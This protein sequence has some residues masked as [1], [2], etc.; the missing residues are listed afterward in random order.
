MKNKIAYCLIFLFVIC[1]LTLFFRSKIFHNTT[2]TVDN[3]NVNIENS[4][5]Y[6]KY[7]NTSGVTVV[8]IWAT[9]CKP[10]MEE[11]PALNKLK[12]QY[13]D[14]GVNFIS[15]SIDNIN[16][17]EKLKKFNATKKFEWDDITLENLE[18]LKLLQNLFYNTTEGS[19]F[20]KISSYNVPRTLIIKNKKIIK[21]YDGLVDYNDISKFLGS[22]LKH[23]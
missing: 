20:I 16:D 7:Y 1:L 3:K 2:V 8:N 18:Y 5:F 22:E 15:F 13:K 9:W 19:S 21:E 6:K 12:S 17:I 10:C 11:I 14:T 4:S 23:N